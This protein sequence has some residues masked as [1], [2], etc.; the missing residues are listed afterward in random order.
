MFVF[1]L[2][3]LNV[4]LA[5][6][7]SLCKI[8]MMMLHERFRSPLYITINFRITDALKQCNIEI[9]ILFIYLRIKLM[10]SFSP[11]FI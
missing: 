3:R 11:Y 6:E 5:G 8:M 7:S 9:Q 10:S 2:F 1:T 4:T